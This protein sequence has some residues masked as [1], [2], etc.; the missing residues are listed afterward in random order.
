MHPPFLCDQHN[1]TQNEKLMLCRPKHM[2]QLYD[3][4][5]A[6]TKRWKPLPGGDH[7]SSVLEEGYFEAMSDFIAEVTGNEEKEKIRS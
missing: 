2:K 3:I 1:A 7:N 5:A 6:P 4:S